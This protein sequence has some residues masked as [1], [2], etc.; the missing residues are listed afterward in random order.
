MNWLTFKITINFSSKF[1]F[2]LIKNAKTRNKKLGEK[3][4]SNSIKTSIFLLKVKKKKNYE[5]YTTIK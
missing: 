1:L 3:S 4:W 5:R 2:E